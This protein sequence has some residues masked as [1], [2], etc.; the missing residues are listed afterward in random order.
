MWI[1]LS[2]QS[3]DGNAFDTTVDPVSRGLREAYTTKRQYNQGIESYR[4]AIDKEPLNYWLWYNL[5]R[6]YAAANNLDG[7]IQA[8]ELGIDK[9]GADP[10]PLMELTNLY[11]AKGDYK[12]AIMIGMRLL[13]VNPAV[14]RL[15]LKGCRDPLI[16]PTSPNN[17]LK[18][19]L[20]R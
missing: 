13:K 14:L 6:A 20:Q 7:A 17:I 1:D 19:S 11:T 15:A 8:C 5:A 2:L 12:A 9:S 4:D 16:M 3:S 10:S 18:I